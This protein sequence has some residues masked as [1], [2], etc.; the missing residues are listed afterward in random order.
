MFLLQCHSNPTSAMHLVPILRS[1]QQISLFF[2]LLW[3]TLLCLCAAGQKICLG[4]KKKKSSIL[5]M[6]HTRPQKAR[7]DPLMKVW[8]TGGALHRPDTNSSLEHTHTHTCT[9]VHNNKNEGFIYNINCMMKYQS[10]FVIMFLWAG[11]S[12][13]LITVALMSPLASE[14][15]QPRWLRG[16]Q[17]HW[18]E[19]DV[20][21]LSIMDERKKKKQGWGTRMKEMTTRPEMD[22]WLEI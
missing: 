2:A 15:I 1:E 14:S 8:F 3:R 7:S 17:T 11:Q 10:W 12:G 18:K 16:H 4:P 9:C 6:T 19:A 5:P 22:K 13:N 20:S 21:K